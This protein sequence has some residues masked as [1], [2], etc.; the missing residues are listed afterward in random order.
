[1]ENGTYSGKFKILPD[2]DVAGN[3]T[4]AG[5]SSFLHVW[6]DKSFFIDIL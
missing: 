3:L 6:S 1:M 4:I 5:P 2:I